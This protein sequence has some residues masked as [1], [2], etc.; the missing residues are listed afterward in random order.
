VTKFT[1]AGALALAL[2]FVASNTADA[3]IVIGTPNYTAG[4]YFYPRTGVI[5]TGFTQPGFVQP[6]YGTNFY[7]TSNFAYQPYSSGYRPFYS[8]Y[9]PY[10]SGYRTYSNFGYSPGFNYGRTGFSTFNG[11]RWR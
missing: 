5:Q 8:G 9:Q 10:N 7:R 11:R 4:N 6:Y 2:G 1:L 3:Q